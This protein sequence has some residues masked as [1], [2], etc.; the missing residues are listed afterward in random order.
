MLKYKDFDPFM[1]GKQLLKATVLGNIEIIKLLL[2]HK[3][4]I[5]DVK[6]YTIGEPT[7]LIY[8][9]N[10]GHIEIMK[11]LLAHGA[12]VC[13]KKWGYGYDVN[14]ILC[15]WK[16]YL[17]K[18]NRFTITASFYPKEFNKI[19]IQ[20]LLCVKHLKPKLPEYLGYLMIE[21]IASMWKQN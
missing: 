17:P 11:L 21:Y 1:I 8:A 5:V 6:D 15:Q 7:A 16:T 18:W 19:A 14:M 10:K 2:K 12:K 4:I 20:W 3:D 9:A 13:E